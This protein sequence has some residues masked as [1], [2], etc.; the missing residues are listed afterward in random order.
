LTALPSPST[1]A[2]RRA[3]AA[4]TVLAAERGYPALNLAAIL[5]RAQLAE[6][7][8]TS[9]FTDPEDAFCVAVEEGTRELLLRCAAAFAPHRGWATQL[10]ALGYEFRDFLREDQARARLMVV[11]SFSACPRS[12]AVRES[13]MAGLTAFLELGRAE[14]A[15]PAS[16]PAGTATITAGTTY[17]RIHRAV[18]SG[19]QLSD[20][21]V[22]ELMYTAV[23]PYLGIDAALAELQM[24]RP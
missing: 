1:S 5:D 11:E 20:E 19:E 4:T 9:H 21:M 10:R 23:R 14:A 2:R 24:P 7:A 12:R 8:F 6:Q 17:N 3:L 18:Q 22:R 15:D 16:I 13:G